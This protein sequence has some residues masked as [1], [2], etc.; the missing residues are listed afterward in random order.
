MVVCHDHVKMVVVEQEILDLVVHQPFF[1]TL[2]SD[3]DICIKVVLVIYM[4]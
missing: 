2:H 3:I 4:D 1:P